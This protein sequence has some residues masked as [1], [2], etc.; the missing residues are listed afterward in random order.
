M[1]KVL[2]TIVLVKVM[3]NMLNLK[4]IQNFEQL[5]DLLFLIVSN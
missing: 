5:E 3:S 2:G 4:A 1:L